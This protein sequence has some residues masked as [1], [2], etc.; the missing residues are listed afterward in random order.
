[1]PNQPCSRKQIGKWRGTD[2]GFAQDFVTC[3]RPIQFILDEQDLSLGIVMRTPGD[4]FDLAT[5][6]L[7]GEGHIKNADE[8][9]S[10]RGCRDAISK[11]NNTDTLR[12]AL[13]EDAKIRA[14]K[15]SA[16]MTVVGSACGICGIQNLP[17]PP[18]FFDKKKHEMIKPNESIWIQAAKDLRTNQAVFAKTGSIH[19]AAIF[20]ADGN[21]IHVKEDI[22]RHNAMDKLIGWS[23]NNGIQSFAD[24]II[25]TSGRA[26]FEI[27]QKVILMEGNYLG[28][29]SA[30]SDLAIETARRY[31]LTLIGLIRDDAFNIYSAGDEL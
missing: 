25:L 17:D 15:A 22:G 23:L 29:I 28:A 16:R 21:L 5:G 26:S 12:V 13:K 11:A 2:V 1:M 9:I 7:Y 3:E 18:K 19:A 20:S 14:I 6:F 31:Q 24:K 10:I 30:P 4:D 8:I 27:V